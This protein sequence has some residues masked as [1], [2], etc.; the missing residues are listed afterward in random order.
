M[1]DE[2]K[3]KVSGEEY[4]FLRTNEHL[5]KNI[6]LLGLGGSYAYGTSIPEKS[7][8][9]IRGVALNSKSEILL[10]ND[11]EQVEETNTDTVVYSFNK[12]IKMLLSSRPNVLEILGCRPEDYLYVSDIGK[13]LIEN[14]K[15]FFSKICI[16]TF[17]N[18]A[19]AQLRRMENKV[20]RLVDQTDHEKHILKTIDNAYW[21]FKSKYCSYTDDEIHLYVDKSERKEH[22]SEIYMNINLKHYPLRDWIGLWDEMKSIVNSYDKV[23]KKNRHA[24]V[25]DK[26]GKHMAHLI[27]VYIM[28]IDILEKEEIITYRADEHDLLM[29]IRNDA[30]L[31]ENSQPTSEFYDLLHDYEKRFEYAKKNTSLPDV[32]DK[33]RIAEFK[34]S[35]N[36]RVV[37][38][39]V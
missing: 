34:A 37:K 27:R 13:E 4:D 20:A 7:D 17:G 30:F 36:E 6:I 14:R 10:G 39:L 26:L 12:M 25:H 11:F 28:G 8:I 22:N 16:N 31:D 32:P 29:K 3:K 23:S 18:Y 24:A 5:G 35:V 21:A 38:E 19:Q 1:I 15:M 33:K 2:I 9:D